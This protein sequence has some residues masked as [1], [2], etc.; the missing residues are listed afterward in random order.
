MRVVRHYMH[1]MLHTVRRMLDP[2]RKD[3]GFAGPW[4]D[5]CKQ[6]LMTLNGRKVRDTIQE[7][8]R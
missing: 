2:R 8:D 4:L 5:L 7:L 3:A 6:G 1:V